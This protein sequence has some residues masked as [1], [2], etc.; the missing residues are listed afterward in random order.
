MNTSIRNEH[1]WVRYSVLL[2]YALKASHL[3]S[4]G[5]LKLMQPKLGAQNLEQQNSV[6]RE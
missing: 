1:S 5:Y 6:F 3:G 2:N 4:P